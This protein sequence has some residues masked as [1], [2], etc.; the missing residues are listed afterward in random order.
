MRSLQR[1]ALVIFIV[2]CLF[3]ATNPSRAIAGRGRAVSERIRPGAWTVLSASQSGTTATLVHVANGNDLVVWEAPVAAGKGYD[4]AVE[5]KPKGGMASRPTNVFGGHDWGALDE[6]P[7]L[8]SQSGRPLLILSGNRSANGADPYRSGCIVGDLLT[9]SGWTLQSWSLS[10]D[11]ST[12][13]F[14][15]TIT[16]GGTLS[17]AWPGGWTNGYGIRY[18]IGVSSTIPATPD[19]QHVSS[20][21]A[22]N[23]AVAEATETGS[24]NIYA[25][26]ARSFSKPASQDGLWAANLSKG[27]AP[28]KAPGTG[29]NIVAHQY[30]PVAIASPTNR[31]GI[32]LAYPNNAW[33]FTKVELWR[34][35]DSTAVTVPGSSYPTSV[36]ISAGP[37]GRL[38]IAW[39]SAQNGTVRVVR[40]NE[41]DNRFGPVETHAGPH[42]CKGDG[43]GTI[44][45]SSG[46]Q[47]RLDVVMSC[48]DG[49]AAHGANHASATQSLVPLQISATTGSI[50]R[51]KGGSVTYRVSDVGDAV[52]GATVR[53][54][55]KRAV[56]DNKG[57]VTFR[58]PKGSKAG[59]FRVKASMANYLNA[60]TSLQ[61]T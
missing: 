22:N 50:N 12:A 1:A 7:T 58:F 47:Q 25:G 9:P 45:I 11:C 5:L 15:A 54:G 10:A 59:V 30:E 4:N 13:H 55:G 27:S 43:S 31:G 52:P 39:W 35:G 40:T 32:Y 34:Y 14:G 19:D 44:K 28:L 37:S 51:T 20:G 16:R 42:G 61:I 49:L 33:P 24:Q 18:R 17:A 53:V 23:L 56:T 29:T 38:W 2:A 8:V 60:A 41:A 21:P 3:I 57:Q 36:S 6:T 46:S 48:Y 26:W